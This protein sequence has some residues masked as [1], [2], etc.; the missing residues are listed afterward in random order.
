M[1]SLALETQSLT[2]RS[3]I[4]AIANTST[5]TFTTL[6]GEENWAIP[7]FQT[8]LNYVLLTVIFTP[9]TMYRYGLKGWLRMVYRDGWKC[10]NHFPAIDQ[11]QTLTTPSSQISSSL[12]VT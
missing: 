5:S 10:M 12:S 9:Y 1:S 6:L 11:I 2:T 8:L 7:T 3:Q 4:L